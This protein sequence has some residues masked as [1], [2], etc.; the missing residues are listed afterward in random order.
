MF[1]KSCILTGTNTADIFVKILR[2]VDVTCRGRSY[3]LLR[4]FVNFSTSL[5]IWILKLSV[6]PWIRAYRYRVDLTPN[7]G[8]GSSIMD[9]DP[10]LFIGDFP[11]ANNVF[12]WIILLVEGGIRF[13]IRSWIRICTLQIITDPDPGGP[14]T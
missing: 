7:P 3:P 9:L 8:I 11:D 6:L 5:V 4:Y 13:R 2:V 1:W 10:A 14:K 12:F